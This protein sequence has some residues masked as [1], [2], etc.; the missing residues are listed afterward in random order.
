MQD[1]HGARLSRVNN[2]DDDEKWALHTLAQERLSRTQTQIVLEK[3]R[4]QDVSCCENKKK[5]GQAYPAEAG[6]A[7]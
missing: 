4:F 3:Q 2:D 1:W 7:H 6:S 5:L